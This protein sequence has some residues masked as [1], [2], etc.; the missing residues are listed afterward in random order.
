VKRALVCEDDGPIR[1]LVTR[2]VEREG[3][4]VDAVGDGEA[5]LVKLRA[6]GY[7]LLVLDLMMPRIGGLEVLNRLRQ[8]RPSHLQR[9]IVMTAASDAV[10]GFI[11]PICTFLPKPFDIDELSRAVRQ[12]ARIAGS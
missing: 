3:F 1:T 11:D 10:Q 6:V 5:A 8:E 4:I 9:V 2:I 12:C 7:D